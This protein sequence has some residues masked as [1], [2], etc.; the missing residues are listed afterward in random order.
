VEIGKKR[1]LEEM[2]KDSVVVVRPAEWEEAIKLVHEKVSS[3]GA[4]SML[5][6]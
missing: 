1:D 3:S 4:V 6:D 5:C 2:E